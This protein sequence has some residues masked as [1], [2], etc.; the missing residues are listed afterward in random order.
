MTSTPF[1]GESI[2]SMRQF[3]RADLELLFDA[4]TELSGLD[5][6]TQRKLL[7]GRIL[8]SAFYQS[9]T[10]TRMAHEA[11]MLF[12]GGRVTGFSDVSVTRAG[13]FYQEPVMDVARVCSAYGDVIVIRHPETGAPAV[14]AAHATVP[15]INA[16]DGWGEHPTQALTDLYTIRQEFGAIDG[17]CLLLVGDLRMRTMRSLVLG[18]RNFSCNIRCV[19]PPSMRLDEALADEFRSAGGTLTEYP[20]VEEALAGA[21][22]IYMEPVIQADYGIGYDHAPAKKPATPDQYRI[23]RAKLEMSSHRKIVL[24]SLPRQDELAA[25]VDSSPFN[26]YWAEVDN[27][28]TLRKALLQL[29]L[30][31]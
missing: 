4:A 17:L 19:A 25:D 7:E 21:D 5:R 26:R 10:R 9:S 27:G 13:D 14:A 15:V 3:E 18:L 30:G 24:H 2:L 23:T 6:R 12:L 22:V 8:V 20:S 29:M 16:G 1:H 31:E 11:A 28:V